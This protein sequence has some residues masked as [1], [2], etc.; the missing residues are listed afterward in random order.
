MCVY[1]VFWSRSFP[2]LALILISCL[3]KGVGSSARAWLRY[4]GH[5]C[6]ETDSLSQELSSC[7]CLFIGVG[8]MSPSPVHAGVVTGLP[9]VVAHSWLVQ[10][11]GGLSEDCFPLPIFWFLQSFCSL[12]PIFSLWERSVMEMSIWDGACCRQ[13]LPSLWPVESF[14][15]NCCPLHKETSSEVWGV[16]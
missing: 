5:A 11:H 9:S 3:L 14:R 2:S 4:E 6:K 15:A 13:L 12:L 10:E 7:Q 8:L 1:N 16:Y